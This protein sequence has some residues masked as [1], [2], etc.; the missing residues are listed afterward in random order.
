[1]HHLVVR[2]MV[3]VNAYY[4]SWQNFKLRKRRY[5]IMVNVGG[6]LQLNQFTDDFWDNH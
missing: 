5:F 4:Y 6:K 1:M 3:D 2:K